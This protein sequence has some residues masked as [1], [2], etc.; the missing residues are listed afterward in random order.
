MAQNA[1]KGDLALA[2][3][4][5]ELE[6]SLTFT[7][8]KDGAD[9]TAEKVMRILMDARIGGFNQ[10]RTEELVQKFGRA[11]GKVKEIVASGLAPEQPLPELP[12]W[13]DMPVPG[14]LAELVA[15]SAA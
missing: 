13:A 2:I 6:A 14:E 15:S 3:D 4:E 12:E 5:D 1:A 8:S 7:P 11:K 10:K 9:W